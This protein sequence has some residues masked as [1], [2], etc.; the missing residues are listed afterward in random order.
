MSIFRMSRRERV[1]ARFAPISEKSGIDRRMRIAVLRARR[2]SRVGKE[3]THQQAFDKAIAEL[4]RTT[5]VST[6]IA[7]W[8]RNEKLIPQ[9]K[10][11]WRKVVR[12]PAF[13]SAVLALVVIA[14]IITSHVM[15]RMK[16][17]PGS[18]TARK[19]LTVASATRMDQLDR[20]DTE[21]GALGDFFLMKYRL[22]HY[23]V[24]PE[25]ASLRTSACRVFDDDQGLRVAQITVPE[26]RMQFFLFPAVRSAKDGKP[27]SLDGW[28]FIEQEGWTGAVQVRDGMCFMAALRGEEKDLAPYISRSSGDGSSGGSSR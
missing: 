19:L 16:D 27:P 6:E 13:L 12:N 1:L 28:R 18:G 9:S 2:S 8:F 26:K 15:E 25:F 5:P 24:A 22:E 23:D 3:F 11:R 10:R 4:V 21:A 7:E 17:F 20:M 14:G